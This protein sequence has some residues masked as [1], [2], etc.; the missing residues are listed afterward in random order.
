MVTDGVVCTCV[1]VRW[2]LYEEF[3]IGL[4]MRKSNA[5]FSTGFAVCGPQYD[6]RGHGLSQP[7]EEG[8]MDRTIIAAAV[9]AV[10]GLSLAACGSA[11]SPKVSSPA[12]APATHAATNITASAPASPKMA[13]IG[14]PVKAGV[15]TFTVT[16]F[17]CGLKTLGQAGA[18]PAPSVP[19][20]GQFCVAV[21]NERNASNQPQ[22][23][24]FAAQML[25]MNGSTYDNNTDPF[26]LTNAQIEYLPAATFSAESAQ[27]QVN[28]GITYQ[29][30]FGWD[31]PANVRAASITIDSGYGSDS[32]TV[33]V[34]S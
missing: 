8:I 15:F 34:R 27:S 5:V 28:P 7:T 25:G 19:Q 29:D 18:G 9:L 21:V 26:V 11:S 23:L 14:E 22:P 6:P 17:L 32:G 4:S 3:A 33:N 2:E 10:A 20:Q 16:K 24:P 13:A 31:V 30:V 1:P 12:A